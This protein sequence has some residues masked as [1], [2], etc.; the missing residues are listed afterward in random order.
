[1]RFDLSYGCYR[2]YLEI[3]GLHGDEEKFC[4][5]SKPDLD[6]WFAF[7]VSEMSLKFRF[8]TDSGDS[9]VDTGFLLQYAGE[10]G[11]ELCK[12]CRRNLIKVPV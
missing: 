7:T 2:E 10:W 12:Y 4:Q 5:Y 9:S 3:V 6:E 11:P 1:M 8:K